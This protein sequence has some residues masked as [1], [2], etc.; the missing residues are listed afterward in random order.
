MA[1]CVENFVCRTLFTYSREF[2]WWEYFA[3]LLLFCRIR[4][5]PHGICALPP[6]FL[7]LKKESKGRLIKEAFR[8]KCFQLIPFEFLCAIIR[9]YGS[10]W[11]NSVGATVRKKVV[12]V[13]TEAY[14]SIPVCMWDLTH[15]FC[16]HNSPEHFFLPAFCFDESTFTFLPSFFPI[17][18]A[19]ELP[20]FVEKMSRNSFM[21][22]KWKK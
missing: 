13:N 17:S 14:I 15:F 18:L 7:S 6:L 3:I 1:Y 5:T 11:K 8:W 2:C 12:L 4:R 19:R 10:A 21:L 22:V 20:P 9:F 16:Y